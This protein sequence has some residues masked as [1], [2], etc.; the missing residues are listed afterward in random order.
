MNQ[1]HKTSPSFLF[2]ELISKLELFCYHCVGPHGIQV[3]DGKKHT[4]KWYV[5]LHQCME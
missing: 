1:V 5:V 3:I 4:Q 2:L